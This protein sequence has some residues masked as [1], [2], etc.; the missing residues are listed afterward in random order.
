LGRVEYLLIL[1]ASI[2]L[3]VCAFNTYV[4][5]PRK[6]VIPDKDKE[7]KFEIQIT[8]AWT[9]VYL[10]QEIITDTI[11]CENKFLTDNDIN[12]LQYISGHGRNMDIERIKVI[13]KWKNGKLIPLNTGGMK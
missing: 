4:R 3:I 11:Y 6:R 9:D 8:I 13:G 7:G 10:R 2:I 1:I 5:F 12:E